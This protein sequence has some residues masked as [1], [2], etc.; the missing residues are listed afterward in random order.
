[1]QIIYII[2]LL[3]LTGKISMTL[4]NVPKSYKPSEKEEYMCPKHLA[5]FKNKLLEWKQ[6][7]LDD[8]QA[9]IEELQDGDWQEPD[10]SDR[11]TLET[12]TGITLRTRNRYLKLISKIDSAL[13]RIEE[14]E[15]GYCEETGEEIGLKRLEARPIATLCIEAQEKHEQVEK[16]YEE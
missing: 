6:E 15:Y 4:P 9:T 3:K 14:G 7:L 11:A 2:Y 5:Y 8:S 10:V 1:M 16:Q 12:D 13:E